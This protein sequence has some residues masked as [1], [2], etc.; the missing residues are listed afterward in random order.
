M[1]KLML[2]PV[3]LLLIFLG[4][5][6]CAETAQVPLPTFSVAPERLKDSPP[7]PVVPTDG[8][9]SA[10]IKDPVK[11]D[12]KEAV[13]FQNLPT[14][15]TE[16][17]DRAPRDVSTYD[18][19]AETMAN[20]RQIK[21]QGYTLRIAE[22]QVPVSKG[23]YDLL[24]G[25]TAQYTRTEQQTGAVG[26][27]SLPI[28][29]SR[30]WEGAVTLQQL[31]PS[32]ATF[33]LAYTAVRT[34]NL[35]DEILPVVNPLTGATSINAKQVNLTTYSNNTVFNVTQ[36]L[37]NGFGTQITNAPIRIAQLEQKGQAADFQTNIETQLVSSL[38]TYWELIGAL[39][40]YKVQIISYAAARDLLRVNT[41]KFNAG[42]VAKTEVLQAEAAAE[43]RR[44]QVIQSRQAVR[45]LEDQL[46]QQ[47][48][49]QKEKPLWVAELRPTQPIAWRELDVDLDKAIQVAMNNRSELRRARS[50]IDQTEVNKMVARNQVLPTLN[51][52]GQVQP[53]GVD[54]DFGDSFDTMADGKYVSYNAGL[55][56]S[57][58][59]QNR[60]A[61]YRYKQ[62]EART[63]QANESLLALQDQITLDVRQAVRDLKTARERIDVSQSQIRSAQATLDAELKRLNVGISTS[64]Q[65]LQFQQD[66]AN[67]Q[68]Q[69]IRAVVDYNEAAFKLERARGT[70]LTTYGVQVEGAD[71]KPDPKPVIWPV[72]FN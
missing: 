67:A 70:L 56:F 50:N 68:N 59:L 64:F 45:N 25:A 8:K 42:V 48:F 60:S 52:F 32:G 6:G 1:S 62:A 24:M 34:V 28:N 58:P 31:L 40:S 4:L 5:L 54:D 39:E 15:V 44:D 2:L 66:V 26:L 7:S 17:Y 41:A 69:H 3:S 29:R 72:G 27:G 35:V 46:K 57:Y 63:Q 30:S 14:S 13:G 47:I 49:L 11:I 61:R 36:P 53:N 71:L 22:Y 19:V 55:Q 18:V 38:Q 16:I 23:I 33:S 12:P 43:A 37:L 21:I 20:N 9:A 51:L 65:V 10:V